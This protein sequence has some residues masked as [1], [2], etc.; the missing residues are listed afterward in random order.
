MRRPAVRITTVLDLLGSAL[1]VLG[2]AVAV[3][4]V[5]V[6]LSLLASGLMTLGVSWLADRR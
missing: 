5:S 6:P 2:V 4:A 3:W 1:V